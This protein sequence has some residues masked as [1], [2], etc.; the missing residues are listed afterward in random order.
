MKLSIFT[1]S[2]GISLIEVMVSL[3]IAAT[4][5]AMLLPGVLV[6][7]TVSDYSRARLASSSEAEAIF[8]K[9]TSSDYV[10]FLIETFLTQYRLDQGG[11]DEIKIGDV[12][13]GEVVT[14][15]EPS[16]NFP[17]KN[18]EVNLTIQKDEEFSLP[19]GFIVE[20]EAPKL[21]VKGSRRKIVHGTYIGAFY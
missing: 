12:P 16:I 2:K 4:A 7:L 10:G 8:D 20:V 9:Y 1:N 3:G 15:S 19:H 6:S 14:V 18:Y 17:G 5:I 21:S 13:H 11:G